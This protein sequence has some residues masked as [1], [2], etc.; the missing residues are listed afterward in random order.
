MTSRTPEAPNFAQATEDGRLFAPS[1]ARNLDPIAQELAHIAPAKGK[2]LEIAS[3]TG[4]HIVAHAANHS[5]INWHPSEVDPDRR[6]SID[7]YVALSDCANLVPP[8]ALN[9]T[10]PGWGTAERYDLIVLSNLLHLISEKD[11]KTL[12]QE[13]A[14]ALAPKGRFF[15]Y[16]P[17]M[18]DGKLVSEG[19]AAFHEMLTQQDALIGYKDD[20]TIETWAKDADLALLRKTEMPANNLA[21]TF[22]RA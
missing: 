7:A 8:R 14:Q 10:E 9:A 2:A 3:G 15:L 12:I 21:F 6:N 5:G 17:F 16:G 19:D 22:E 20:K 13:V 18:R 11:A 1:A 4:Q